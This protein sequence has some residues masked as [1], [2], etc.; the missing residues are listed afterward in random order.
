MSENENEN[1][2]ENERGR[3]CGNCGAAIDAGNPT[4]VVCPAKARRASH[5][6]CIPRTYGPL[7]CWRPT[8]S[9]VVAF[10]V[11]G[12]LLAEQ[13]NQPR[14]EFVALATL[15]HRLGQRVVIWSQAGEE[16]AREAQVICDLPWADL[17]EKGAVPVDVTFDDEAVSYGRVTN[18]LVRRL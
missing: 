11:D 4:L 5:D 1:E 15:F 12:V 16:R 14:V 13:D 17:A 9:L 10:D 3:V 8:Q 2:N 6:M 7:D 18:I